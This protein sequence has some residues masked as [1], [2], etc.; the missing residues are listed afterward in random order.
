[1]TYMPAEIVLYRLCPRPTTE[2]HMGQTPIYTEILGP[3][4]IGVKTE[5]H[6]TS[7]TDRHLGLPARSTE[8]KD[9]QADMKT[10]RDEKRKKK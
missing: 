5:A 4:S 10:H 9:I 7:S 1:M 2:S 8:T 6:G 3:D